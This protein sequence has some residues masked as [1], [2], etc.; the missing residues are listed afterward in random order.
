MSFGAIG[1]STCSTV[2]D[3]TGLVAAVNVVG[4]SVRHTALIS[5]CGVVGIASGES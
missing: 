5:C 4:G 2:G 3:P 1:D